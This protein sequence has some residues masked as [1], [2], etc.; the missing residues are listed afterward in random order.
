VVKIS[1]IFEENKEYF[2]PLISML[3]TLV[4]SEK[5]IAPKVIKIFSGGIISEF[6]DVS[7]FVN[8]EK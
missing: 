3:S 8:N 4:L 6:I 7:L 5:K 2:D 1:A